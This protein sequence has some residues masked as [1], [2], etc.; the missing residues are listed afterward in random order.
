MNRS[1][2]LNNDFIQISYLEI[3][4][5]YLGEDES[6]GKVVFLLF[7]EWVYVVKCD[8]DGL[9]CLLLE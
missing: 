2:D 5:M 3:F 9:A 4:L 1:E 8:L 7:Y 6:V